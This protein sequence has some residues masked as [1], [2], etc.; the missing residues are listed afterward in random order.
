MK[1]EAEILVALEAMKVSIQFL[2]TDIW[3]ISDF[4]SHQYVGLSFHETDADVSVCEKH[5]GIIIDG[6]RAAQDKCMYTEHDL[7]DERNMLVLYC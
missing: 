2:S 7:S 1:A 5:V 4:I 3:D 6:I